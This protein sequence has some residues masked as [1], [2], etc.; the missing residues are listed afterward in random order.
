MKDIRYRTIPPKDLERIRSLWEELIREAAI[1]SVDFRYVY[2]D[3]K[4]EDRASELRKKADSGKIRIEIAEIDGNDLPVA[5]CVA[6][7]SSEMA[8]EIDS[9]LVDRNFRGRGI[10]SRLVAGA[11]GWF[12]RER[13]SPI[14]IAVAEGNHEAFAFYEKFGF[15]RRLVVMQRK[16]R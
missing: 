4:F 3:R 11:L 1:R 16:E 13:A 15:A 2:E 12:D 10:G 5:Y 6:T 8:G 14:T 7:V 9:I